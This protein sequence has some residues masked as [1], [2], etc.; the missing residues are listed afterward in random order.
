MVEMVCF[1]LYGLFE[2]EFNWVCILDWRVIGSERDMDMEKESWE[3]APRESKIEVKQTTVESEFEDNIDWP[4]DSS[5]LPWM[6]RL[7]LLDLN[8]NI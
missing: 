6:I 3:E 5:L 8:P 7:P 2:I 1:I 4:K